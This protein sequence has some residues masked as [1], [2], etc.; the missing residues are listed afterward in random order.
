MSLGSADMDDDE[1]GYGTSDD[2]DEDADMAQLSGADGEVRSC[3]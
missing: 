1:D 2:E 3:H